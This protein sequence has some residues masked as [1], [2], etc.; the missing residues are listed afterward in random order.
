MRKPATWTAIPHPHP[1]PTAAHMP[2]DCA[3]L[4]PLPPAASAAPGWWR[5][6]RPRAGVS[7]SAAALRRVGITTPCPLPDHTLSCPE[8]AFLVVMHRDAP[9]AGPSETP[10]GLDDPCSHRLTDHCLCCGPC[11]APSA[12]RSHAAPGSGWP[13]VIIFH[14]LP[15]ADRQ[16]HVRMRLLQEPKGQVPKASFQ[17]RRGLRNPTPS[18][19]ATHPVQQPDGYV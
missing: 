15:A 5:C 2:G 8:L 19:P 12:A 7:Q 13:L 14:S 18:T 3:S 17:H 1:P 16:R 4:P 6:G 10:P 11:A 9:R